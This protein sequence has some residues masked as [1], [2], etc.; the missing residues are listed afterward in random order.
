MSGALAPMTAPSL[1][2]ADGVDRVLGMDMPTPSPKR[3]RRPQAERSADTRGL[4]LEAVFMRNREEVEKSIAMLAEPL[5]QLYP[6]LALPCLA[7]RSL[8]QPCL[9]CSRRPS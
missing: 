1:A 5:R 6:A 3:P 8:A 2:R 9:G 4:A 7:H